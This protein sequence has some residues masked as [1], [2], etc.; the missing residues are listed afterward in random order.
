MGRPVVD[1]MLCT[2]AKVWFYAWMGWDHYL[3]RPGVHC[4]TSA[5]VQVVRAVYSSMALV[6][7]CIDIE[8]LG[9]LPRN[10]GATS[11][12]TVITTRSKPD[13]MW[14]QCLEHGTN[15]GTDSRVCLRPSA[16]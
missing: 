10:H 6:L 14:W 2:R 5:L 15:A 11:T 13:P 7:G 16:A 1:I 8:R 9:H 12:K 3:G 4:N